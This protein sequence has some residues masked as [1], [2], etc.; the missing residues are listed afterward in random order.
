VS[1]IRLPLPLQ[2]WQLRFVCFGKEALVKDH[3]SGRLMRR[4]A[5]LFSENGHLQRGGRHSAGEEHDSI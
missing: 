4:F 1:E 3:V 2:A 5:C